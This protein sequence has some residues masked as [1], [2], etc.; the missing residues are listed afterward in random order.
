MSIYEVKMH[1]NRSSRTSKFVANQCLGVKKVYGGSVIRGVE[2]TVIWHSSLSPS[3]CLSIYCLL[4]T[5]WSKYRE[6]VVKWILIALFICCYCKDNGWKFKP[7]YQ[8]SCDMSQFYGDINLDG[9]S[10]K[11]KTL[12]RYIS[13]RQ[14]HNLPSHQLDLHSNLIICM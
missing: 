9:W 13:I 4:V 7:R 11:L 1:I 8:I 2:A 5:K 10:R 6:S 3:G 14:F 12:L